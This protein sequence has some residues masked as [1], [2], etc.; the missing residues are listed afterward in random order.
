MCYYNNNYHYHHQLL[1][2]VFLRVIATSLIPLDTIL[3]EIFAF[4]IGFSCTVWTK[5]KSLAGSLDDVVLADDFNSSPS[6]NIRKGRGHQK[7]TVTKDACQ[8]LILH[9]YITAS[10]TRN[11]N[12]N[13]FSAAKGVFSIVHSYFET[14]CCFTMYLT[15]TNIPT[16]QQKKRAHIGPTEILISFSF[17]RDYSESLVFVFLNGHY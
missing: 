4:I 3:P 5:M 1:Q 15:S 16:A 17:F 7:G 2:T 12:L 9:P 8:R 10:R 6:T 13:A 14:L 11:Y